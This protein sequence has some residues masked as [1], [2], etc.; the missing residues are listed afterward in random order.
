[1]ANPS[2]KNAGIGKNIEEALHLLR[3]KPANSTTLERVRLTAQ[4]DR[5]VEALP[6]PLQMGRGLQHI[7]DNISI[8]VEPH[9][10]LIGRISEEVPSLEGEKFFQDTVAHMGARP[11]WMDDWGHEGFRWDILLQKGFVGLEA[12]AQA[13]LDNHRRECGC[14]DTIIYLEGA[15]LIYQALRN[16]TRRAAE[17]ATKAGL[18]D[19]AKCL[20]AIADNPPKTFR[21]ALQ[22]VWI[23]ELVYC[24]IAALNPTLTLGRLDML[25]IDFYKNDIA[26]GILDEESAGKLITDFYCKNNIIMG[27]GEHQLSYVDGADTGWER[28]LCYDSPQY[29]TLGGLDASGNCV[30]NELT[31]IFVRNIVSRFKNPFIVYRYCN[32]S[33]PEIWKMV[34]GKLADGS[35]ILIYNDHIVINAL[36]NGGVSPEDAAQYEMFGCNWPSVSGNSVN[37]MVF[38]TTYVTYILDLLKEISEDGTAHSLDIDM[39]YERLENYACNIINKEFDKAKNRVLEWPATRP[40]VLKVDGCFMQGQ[41]WKPYAVGRGSVDYTIFTFVITH[42]ASAIDSLVVLDKLVFTEKKFSLGDLYLALKSN[43]EGHEHLRQ[44]C[45]NA[46]KYGQDDDL[47][48]GHAK[49]LVDIHHRIIAKLDASGLCNKGV[50]LASLETDSANVQRGEETAATPDG[51]I[52]GAQLSHCASPS[53]GSCING[54]TAMLMSAAK[55]PKDIIASGGLNVQLNKGFVQE[56]LKRDIFPQLVKAYFDSGGMQIQCTITSLDELRAAQLDPDKYR[57]L[58]VRITGY[59]ASFVEM[60]KRAQDAFIAREE[61]IL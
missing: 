46:P 15:V 21:Q 43:F 22:A 26:S 3:F 18:H 28:N 35:S 60:S 44:L 59:S 14:E 52:K 36:I 6:Q 55:A 33:D 1:M 11:P 50:V 56:A 54:L 61:M 25:L 20:L 29:L 17:A 53:W 40:G 49:R 19:A 45:V 10:L 9:D 47:T 24:T 48:N 2:L 4:A 38:H 12:Q 58:M 32:Q 8:P 39:F 37:P 13:L 51:R 42:L 23:L 30:D 41:E 57:D 27:R 5:L 31:A 34:C 7:L 16:Y